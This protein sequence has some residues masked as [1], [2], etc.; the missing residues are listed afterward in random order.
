MFSP[1]TSEELR[2][3]LAFLSVLLE[4][5]SLHNPPVLLATYHTIEMVLYTVCTYSWLFFAEI[6]YIPF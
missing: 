6:N 4:L 2:K 1:S 5:E 3:T